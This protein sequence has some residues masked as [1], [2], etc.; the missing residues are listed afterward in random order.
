MRDAAVKAATALK[1]AGTLVKKGRTTD[2]IDKLVH[3]F[4]IRMNCYPSPL[5]YLGFP[6]S[7]C[8]SI[9][10]VRSFSTTF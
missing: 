3:D 4:I 10:E 5:M 8:T 6:K 7:I 9:N 1:Y 2:E